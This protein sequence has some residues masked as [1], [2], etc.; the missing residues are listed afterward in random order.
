MKLKRTITL[1]QV[2]SRRYRYTRGT[3]GVL[4]LLPVGIPLTIF[5]LL[6]W[7][8]E[9]CGNWIRTGLNLLTINI[10]FRGK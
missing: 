10:W 5:I 2:R 8:A 7:F 1:N 9:R 4:L 6:G 3:V